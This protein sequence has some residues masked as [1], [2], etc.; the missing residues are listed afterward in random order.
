V[1]LYMEFERGDYHKMDEKKDQKKNYYDVLGVPKDA[2]E[3]VIKKAYKKLAVKWHPDKHKTEAKKVEAEVKFKELGEAYATLGDPSKRRMYDMTNGEFDDIP[4]YD[5]DFEDIDP[6]KP[7]TF[8]FNKKGGFQPRSRPPPPEFKQPD[9]NELFN[10]FLREQEKN[11]FENNQAFNPANLG[12]NHPF[13]KENPFANPF[14]TQNMPKFSFGH[15]NFPQPPNPFGPGTGGGSFT[16]TSSSSTSSSS[17]STSPESSNHSEE[18]KREKEHTKEKEQIKE[19][20][21]DLSIIFEIEF[22]IK[23]LYCGAKRKLTYKAT[24]PCKS[25]TTRKAGTGTCTECQN[26]GEVKGER[27]VIAEIPPGMPY[28][29]TKVFTGDGHY[30]GKTRRSGDLQI[31]IKEPKVN[32]YPEYSREGEDLIYHKEIQLCDLLCGSPIYVESLDDQEF[33]YTEKEMIRDGGS[34]RFNGRGFP[35]V[36]SRTGAPTGGKGDLVVKYKVVFPTT[37]YTG[38]KAEL[39]KS[40][41]PHEVYDEESEDE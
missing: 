30:N 19:K 7:F 41:L 8:P 10:N 26:S 14:F 21:K 23:D 15:F 22:Q 29:G 24:L 5:F 40:I 38:Q 33:S 16:T 20:E 4:E 34:R 27:V 37:I 28:G 12:D 11:F 39:L 2:T 32:K 25:C 1:L 13:G 35:L 6:D 36:D 31:K 3:D 18:K 17:S 9:Y